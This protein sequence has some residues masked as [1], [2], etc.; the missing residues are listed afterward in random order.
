MTIRLTLKCSEQC[1]H[2]LVNA[3]PTGTHITEE[4]LDNL[5]QLLKYVNVPILNISGG[6]F[7][8]NPDWFNIINKIILFIKNNNLKTKL[9]LQSNGTFIFDKD[10]TQKI[11]QIIQD[12]IIYKLYISTNK[13]W[14]KDYDE[15][16]KF[17]ENINN[18][19]IVLYLNDRQERLANL[20]RAKDL[21]NVNL[22]INA[23]CKLAYDT[24]K[25]KKFN[26]LNEFFNI[27][28]PGWCSPMINING[29]IYLGWGIECVSV[30]NINTDSYKQI[31]NN[32]INYVP[33]RK[34]KQVI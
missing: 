25:Q 6:E 8:E 34:C 5:L 30:G 22:N 9:L 19:K 3:L 16:Y 32:I 33:C 23:S 1:K 15:V 4:T 14:Y 21:E 12:S 10:K 26:N 31:Y 11:F 13:I 20:G 27:M 7:T 2:C 28:P 17:F 24:I 18:P 29:N